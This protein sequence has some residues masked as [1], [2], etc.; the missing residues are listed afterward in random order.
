MR[1]GSAGLGSAKGNQTLLSALRGRK[2]LSQGD[3]TM[4]RGN[5]TPVSLFKPGLDVVNPALP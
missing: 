2:R 3:V 4:R 5:G 1:T